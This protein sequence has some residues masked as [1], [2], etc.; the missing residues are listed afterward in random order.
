MHVIAEPSFDIR[1]CCL[2]RKGRCYSILQMIELRPSSL[3]LL[4]TASK[5]N[6]GQNSSPLTHMLIPCPRMAQWCALVK[7]GGG[8]FQMVK[9]TTWLRNNQCL[10]KCALN[11]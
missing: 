11:P 1:N 7:T 8:N 9:S 4:V 6:T 3:L 2:A 10:L 5:K